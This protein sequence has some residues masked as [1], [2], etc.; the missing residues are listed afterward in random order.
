MS[1]LTGFKR[2]LF[3]DKLRPG[4][5]MSVMIEPT[6]VCN[7]RCIT[8]SKQNKNNISSQSMNLNAFRDV[9]NQFPD[10]DNIIFCGIGEPLLNPDIVEMAEEAKKR[11]PSIVRLVT[12]GSVLTKP[13]IE[14]LLPLLTHIQISINGFSPKGYMRFNGID[15]DLFEKVRENIKAL[16][17]LRNSLKS[18]LKI[19]LSAVLTRT[20]M[21][22]FDDALKFCEELKVDSFIVQQLNHFNNR[23]SHLMVPKKEEGAL[24]EMLKREKRKYKVKLEFLSS[25]S[26]PRCYLLWKAAYISTDGGVTPC[27]GYYDF[28]LKWNLFRSN[29]KEIWHSEDFVNMRKL[30]IARRFSYCKSCSNGPLFNN[31]TFRWFYGRYMKPVLKKLTCRV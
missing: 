5:P 21:K 30:I 11:K 27:N 10:L 24:L 26:M 28:P 17:L 22:E 31:I 7:F 18:N 16:V 19:S 15:E 23:L 20:N 4:L 14:K 25:N 6:T 29:F 2:I 9:I 1:I 8:C 12:N 3:Y 13:L